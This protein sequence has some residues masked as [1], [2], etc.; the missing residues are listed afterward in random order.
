[1]PKPILLSLKARKQITSTTQR[2]GQ[3]LF[4]QNYIKQN[5]TKKQKTKNKKT[6][7]KKQKERKT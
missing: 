2:S 3:S 4:K 7:N 1:M 5:K 6:K